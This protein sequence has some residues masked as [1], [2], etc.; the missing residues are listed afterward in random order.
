MVQQGLTKMSRLLADD[1]SGVLLG[2]WQSK[3]KW[4][5]HGD[6]RVSGL[7]IRWLEL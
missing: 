2:K 1:G 5:V 4:L 7:E 3:H 6:F